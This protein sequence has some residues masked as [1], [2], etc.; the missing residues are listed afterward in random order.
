MYIL[1]CPCIQTP[2]L[3]ATGITNDNDL[4]AF[5]KV[6][7][8]CEIFGIKTIVLPCAETIYLGP[9]HPPG[10]YIGRLDTPEFTRLL[11][12]LEQKVRNT[13][14]I[15]GNP[16]AIIGVDSSPVCGV[17]ST[18][19]GSKDNLSPKIS[20]RGVFL[21]KF[22]EIPAYDVYDAAC[23]KV[24]L[25]APLFSEAE[26]EYNR[27]LA[28]ILSK[29]AI[30]TYLP[31]DFGDSIYSREIS[32]QKMIFEKNIE[33]INEADIVI[34][35]I[36][37]AD[38]DSGTSWEIGY[39]FAKGKKIISLRTDFRRVGYNESVNLMLEESSTVL[40]NS[41]ALINALP[42]PILTNSMKISSIFDHP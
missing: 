41:S 38:A 26:R 31:Q 30:K 36:D 29:Y 18:W 1:L 20:G 12:E 11:S 22:S 13:F 2:D 40:Y 17:H 6:L 28:D 8:R 10:H 7:S 25:A 19:Y 34:S 39:A 21:S 9:N 32:S 3:R 5:K 33:A 27:K 23:W 14:K 24:Y 42:C 15:Y 37:G 35:I 16:Q 4:Q